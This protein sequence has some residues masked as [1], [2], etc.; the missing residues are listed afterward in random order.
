M[1]RQKSPPKILSIA[2]GAIL[3]AI[4]LIYLFRISILTK[5]GHFLTVDDPL[6]PVNIIF[7]L[8]GDVDTRPF[9]AVKIFNQGFAPKIVISQ[10]ESTPSV[11]LGIYPSST[12]AAINVMKK[13]GV[14]DSS[15]VVLETPGGVTSTRDEALALL[16]YVQENSVKSLIIVTTAFHG[17]RTQ[18]TFNRVLGSMP[19]K[20]LVSTGA[21]LNFDE[22][23]WW[24]H[25]D[26][27]LM[28]FDEY[29]KLIYY[30]LYY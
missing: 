20:F 18:W 12:D 11:E 8:T 10:V 19:A 3:F 30:L 5:M 6:E 21:H 14:N 2:L 7:V 24:K 22:T 17:R 15:I 9:H 26:G 13:L 25:E 29:L 4:L 16:K 1:P 23:N 27:F 28:F